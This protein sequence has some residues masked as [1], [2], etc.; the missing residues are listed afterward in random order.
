MFS[1]L[2]EV[3]GGNCKF[4]L[5]ILHFNER[6]PS[7]KIMRQKPAEISLCALYNRVGVM[8]GLPI[9][10]YLVE[11]SFHLLFSLSPGREGFTK[12]HPILSK[13]QSIVKYQSASFD[14]KP[15]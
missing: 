15:I 13:I 8:P 12:L 5:I 1:I 3:L 2:L 11:I 9:S 7:V 6:I 10:A 14:S 4:L